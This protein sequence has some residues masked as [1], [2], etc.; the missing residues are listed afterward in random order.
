[1]RNILFT[2]VL[3]L[4]AFNIQA[5]TKA[6]TIPAHLQNLRLPDFKLLLTDSSTSFY[7][8]QLSK[9]K[10]TVLMSFSPDCDHCKNQTKE[11]IENIQKLK[12]V[13]IVMATTY[14]FEMMKQFYID[15]QI[16]TYK[17]II[18]GR[19]VL[20]FFPKY[21][22]NH[23]LPLITIYNKNGELIHYFDGG[24]PTAKLIELA[25]K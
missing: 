20:Y 3:F 12:S 11:L 5:Q 21:Y 6:D 17:N 10:T 13:Q 14:P 7:T 23:Y 25:T 15:Y 2:V 18:M 24:V 19:D 8:E 16:S 9:K 4:A 1:M 22:R